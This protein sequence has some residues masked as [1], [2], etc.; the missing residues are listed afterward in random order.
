MRKTP[1]KAQKKRFSFDLCFPS[2]VKNPLTYGLRLIESRKYTQRPP[3]SPA[4]SVFNDKNAERIT[5]TLCVL[6][7]L[8]ACL[9][10]CR[11]STIS[12]FAEYNAFFRCTC[13]FFCNRGISVRFFKNVRESAKI[14][15]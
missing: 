6:F 15:T 12:A 14:G 4:A 13:R 10:I 3:G 2:I 5:S 7:Y 9:C 8:F 1:P 11:H